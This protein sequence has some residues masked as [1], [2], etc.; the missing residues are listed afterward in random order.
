MASPASNEPLHD[1]TY[2]PREDTD[3]IIDFLSALRDRGRQA[4]EP[5]LG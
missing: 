4:A 2:L 5:V 1:Q 3:E